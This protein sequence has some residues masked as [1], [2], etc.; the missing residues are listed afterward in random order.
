MSRF[1]SPPSG[2]TTGGSPG[3]AALFVGKAA[4]D[5]TPH[6]TVRIAVTGD[7]PLNR[8]EVAIVDTPDFQRLRYIRQLGITHLVYPTAL[9]TRFDHSLGTL[10]MATVM[11][12]HIREN[13]HSAPGERAVTDEQEQLIRL[14][15]LLHD[16]THVPFGHTLEDETS[17]FSRHDANE[18][19]IQRFL[20]KDSP[21]GKIIQ[22]KLGEEFYGRFMGIYAC[23]KDRLEE[24][25]EDLFI[26]DLVNNTVC[27]DLLDYLHRDCYFCNV[28]LETDF[29][30]LRYLYIGRSGTCRRLVIRLWKRGKSSP[31]PDIMTDLI[32]L[33]EN[34]YALGERVYFH[35]AKLIGGAMLADAVLREHRAGRL[36]EKDLWDLTDDLLLDRLTRSKDKTVA[37]LG[38][39][40]RNR[41]LW[42]AFY[43]RSRREVEAEQS[44]DRSRDV[45]ERIMSTWWKDAGRRQDDQDRIA[46][47]LG[48]DPGDLIIYCPDHK[49]NLK[50]ADMTVFWNGDLRPLRKCR[51]NPLIAKKL[52]TILESHRELW[53]LR[54]FI[55]PDRTDLLRAATEALDYL[56]SF[57]SGAKRP[58]GERYY[59]AV[60]NRIALKKGLAEMPHKEFADRSKRAVTALL[61]D[62]GAGRDPAT[63]E[64]VVT[65][66][67]ARDTDA[68]PA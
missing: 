44:V 31:R 57:G 66:A 32:R 15:A 33:L 61:Q 11:L 27:A 5:L 68:H 21:I 53:S 39:A 23:A 17:V 36:R 6:K 30:F 10:G 14:L 48:A 65:D 52:E 51:D 2:E 58:H 3:Q 8:L 12:R 49:M 25:G 54:A 1:E 28:P 37:R 50:P 35:H 45:M 19:R 13:R 9:H 46:G 56:F 29:R 18:D 63:V 26:Y 62:T 4:I 40:V 7:V 59:E 16:V 47:N 64:K 42:N 60:V 22:H 34:R 55:S 41:S 38:E 20:G 43:E 24:L 67:F